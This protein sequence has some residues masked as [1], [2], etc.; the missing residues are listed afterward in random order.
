MQHLNPEQVFDDLVAKCKKRGEKFKDDTFCHIE[1][2]AYYGIDCE[3]EICDLEWLRAD[4]IPHFVDDEGEVCLC[5]HGKH[6]DEHGVEKDT[7]HKHEYHSHCYPN[8]LMEACLSN[9]CCI[10]CTHI[11]KKLFKYDCHTGIYCVNLWAKGSCMEVIVDDCFLCRE[12][13]PIYGVSCTGGLWISVLE[14]A[15]AKLNGHSYHNLYSQSKNCSEWYVTPSTILTQITHAPT[16]EHH[17]SCCD[18]EQLNKIA[19]CCKMR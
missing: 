11:G 15:L 7:C 12:N 3:D 10:Y 14:K 19:E 6:T 4:K 18:N 2:M 17:L 16:M 1:A 5:T 8:S 13:E 9:G